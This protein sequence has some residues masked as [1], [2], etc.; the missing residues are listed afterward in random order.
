MHNEYMYG[1]I[2][3]FEKY[4]KR[5]EYYKNNENEDPCYDCLKESFSTYGIP[6]NYKKNEYEEN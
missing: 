5:C 6:V 3:E 2:V 4:C 1:H